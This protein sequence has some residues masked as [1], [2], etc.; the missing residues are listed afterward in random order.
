MTPS[1]PV[2][3]KVQYLRRFFPTVGVPVV[4]AAEPTDGKDGRV[5]VTDGLTVLVSD[6]YLCVEVDRGPAGKFHF[7]LR[8]KRDTRRVLK[9]IGRA[10]FG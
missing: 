4:S 9:D 5:V 8:G 10:V 1:N 3:T 2:E 6:V 7:P